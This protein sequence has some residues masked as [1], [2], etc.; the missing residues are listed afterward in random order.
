MNRCARRAAVGFALLSGLAARAEVWTNQAGHT[1]SGS[2]A[3]YAGGYVSFSLTN[4]ATMR[5]PLSALRAEDQRRVLRMR[6]ESVAPEFARQACRDA[7]AILARYD[8]IPEERRSGA[9]RQRAWRMALA[10]FDERIAAHGTVGL[11]AEERSAIDELRGTL[12]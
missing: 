12:R 7:A 11:S 6:G 10:A 4:G 5:M 3:G 9:D 1:L 8:A 2:L